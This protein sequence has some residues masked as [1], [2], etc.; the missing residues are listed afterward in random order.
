VTAGP[1]YRIC[2]TAPEARAVFVTEALE[3]DDAVFLATHS[4]ITGFDFAGRDAAE[5]STADER[6]VLE[7]LSD[8]DRRHAF[9]V[10]QGEPGSGKSHLIRWL[11]VNWSQPTDVKLLLRRADGS[12]E[13]A[14]R[15]LRNRLPSE[16]HELF[17]GLGQRQKASLKGRA[18]IFMATLAA[19]LEPGH[20]DDRI[21]DEEW[22][23]TF[24]PAD[25]LNHPAVR[26]KWSGPGRILDL[27]EGAGGGRNSATASFDVFDVQELAE[28]VGRASP[29]VGGGARELL[30]RLE[31]EAVAIRGYRENDWLAGE[32]VVDAADEIRTTVAMVEA[33]NRRRNDAIQNVLGVSA[34]GLKVLFRKIRQ[35]LQERGQRLIL[36]LEDITSWEGLDDSLIDVLVFNADV[37]GD[38]READ[39]CPLI[40]VVG[41][42][43]SYYQKLAG[44]YRQR[45]T[46]ELI[47]GRLSGSLQDVASLREAEDRRRFAARYLAAVRA[48]VPALNGWLAGLPDE[49][50]ARPPNVCSSC[51]AREGCFAT[52]G[53]VD[54]IGLF[55]FNEGALDRFFLALKEN[56]DG[57]TWRTPRGML[58]AVLNPNLS[59]PELIELGAFPSPIVETAALSRDRRSEIAVSNRLGQMISV[60]VEDVQERNRLRRAITYWGE[61]ERSDTWQVGGELVFAGLSRSVSTVFKLPWLGNADATAT[62]AR[63]GGTVSRPEATTGKVLPVSGPTSQT[64]QRADETG[65][66]GSGAASKV[67]TSPTKGGRVAPPP[68]LRKSRTQIERMRE[69][70][71][72]WTAGGS[73][74]NSS[75]WNGML[76][77]FVSTFDFRDIGIPRL[78]Y[79]RIVTPEMVKLLGSSSGGRDY[80]IVP[81]EDWVRNGLEAH[82]DLKLNANVTSEDAAYGRR[83]L[84]L[85][86]RRLHATTRAYLLRRVPGVEGGGRWSPAATSIQVLLARAWLRG[87]TSPEASVIDQIQVVL[88]DETEVTTDPAAR[89]APWQEWLNATAKWQD[90]L[91]ADLRSMV[92]IPLNDGAA[93]AGLTDSSEIAGAVLR[94]RTTGQMDAVPVADGGLH[95]NFRKLRELAEQWSGRRSV[96]ERTELAQV[97]NRAIALSE[98]LRGRSIEAHLQR[99]DTAISRTSTLL[100]KEAVDMV[101]AWNQASA[102]IGPRLEAKTDSVEELMSAFKDEEGV[103]VRFAERIAWLAAA[104]AR[105]LEDALNL[106]Q[107]GEKLVAVLHEHAADCVR[108][109]RGIGSL[110]ALK[111]IG[112]TLKD[113]SEAS[114][115]AEVSGE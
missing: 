94:M 52:F 84:A 33:L 90:R 50:E 1:L 98:L 114:V 45:I 76:H 34:Q 55:P 103:P 87:S 30:R 36:L 42:T 59:Q 86:M 10:V 18:N 14:L 113:V 79:S 6:S 46:H 28:I 110:A 15:Q 64:D 109:A 70:L 56:D 4:P 21:G 29:A 71:L 49:P 78:L 3:G 73:L 38:E 66:T 80:L 9:C 97:R 108:E 39:V 24:R 43:P 67:P 75:N 25:L 13:G 19:T 31:T 68:R 99:L 77:E 104:P 60:Q 92:S 72:I 89:C 107:Q 26:A 53:E 85:M 88:S 8:P 115:G 100:T 57:Q 11:S 27:L 37:R 5:F 20:F 69:E 44:N 106:A 7:T 105:E 58:Q 48:G 101:A 91:R 40:S 16:F 62:N 17:E 74:E 63:D 47:L 93:G 111:Q 96:I 54:G 2:W 22:C 102:R 32:I 61:P 51:Y 65:Q 41:V 81:R 95:E 82:L 35:A 112:Q 12:L 83:N 23:E